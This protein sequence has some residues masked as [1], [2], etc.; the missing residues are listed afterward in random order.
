M[1]DADTAVVPGQSLPDTTTAQPS[2]KVAILD[3]GFVPIYWVYLWQTLNRIS[4]HRFVVFYGDPPKGSGWIA[5]KGPFDFPSKEAPIREINLFGWKAVW[6]PVVREVLFNKYD[7]LIMC[8]ELKF[9]S[10][11]LMFPIAKLMGKTVIYWGFGYQADVG[12]NF[13]EKSNPQVAGKALRIKDWLAKRADGY[14]AYTE[15]GR[16]RMINEVGLP[17]EKVWVVRQT[18]DVERQIEFYNTYKDADTAAIRQEFGLRPDSHVLL[19]FGRLIIYKRVHE[20]IDVAR[21]LNAEQ[22]TAKPVDVVIVGEGDQAEALRTRADGDPL[23]HFT[24][25]LTHD[26]LARLIKVADAAVI[27]GVV[28]ITI[29]HTM[30]HGLPMITRAHAMHSPEIDYLEPDVNGLMVEGDGDAFVD[31]VARYLNDPAEQARLRDGALRT[32]ESISVEH[33]SKQFDNAV[34]AL[35]AQ[36]ASA[37]G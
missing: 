12:I 8:H 7:A 34:S 5:A 18:G 10:N 28:G 3:L 37:A 30:A 33:M 26:P 16:D 36:R 24:G 35:L 11:L 32:R 14:L 9:L 21:R 31:A 19:F 25:R 1:S 17:P 6:M 15:R 27:P 22:R 2:A 4:R 20:L 29:T 23:V 13:A